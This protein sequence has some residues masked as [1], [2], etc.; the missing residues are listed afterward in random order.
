MIYLK[1]SLPVEF[2][3]G[4]VVVEGLAVVVVVDVGCL[5]PQGLGS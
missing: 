3:E 4:D 1:I 5:N 2:E